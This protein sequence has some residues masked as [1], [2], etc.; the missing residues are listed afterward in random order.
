MKIKDLA[1]FNR[2]NAKL[3][4]YG[5]NNLDDAELLAI[6]FGRGNKRESALELSNK[7]LSKYNWNLI[8]DL[9]LVELNIL[10][11]D[12]VK[13]YQIQAIAE[14]CKRHSKLKLRSFNPKIKSSKDVFNVMK[15]EIRDVKKEHLYALYLDSQNEIIDKPEMITMGLLDKS[16]VHP[17]EVFKNAIRKSAKSI[18]VVHNH[19]SG[20]VTPSDAD[21][22]V[23]AILKK[24]GMIID[25]KLL[26]H[27]IIGHDNYYSFCDDCKL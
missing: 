21:Q 4:K 13:S 12:E 23:T 24:A 7:I 1:W 6:I 17:R 3:K 8:S 19:P 11:D 26:D 27:L 2:P 22:K 18:I 14:I 25:I 5:V 16:L 15:Y 20:D 9:S 10:L